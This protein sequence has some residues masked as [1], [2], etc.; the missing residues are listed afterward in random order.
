M[1]IVADGMATLVDGRCY[2]HCDR[3]N[4]HIGWDDLIM[5]DIISFVAVGMA[6]GSVVCLILSSEMLNRTSSHM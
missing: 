5:T 4:N 6:T 2:C 3:W 1:A